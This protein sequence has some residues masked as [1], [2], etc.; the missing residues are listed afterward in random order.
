MKI[1]YNDQYYHYFMLIIVIGLLIWGIVTKKPFDRGFILFSWFSVLLLNL[2]RTLLCYLNNKL[3]LS[4]KYLSISPIFYSIALLY[5]LIPTQRLSQN[6]FSKLLGKQFN[7]PPDTAYFLT[8]FMALLLLL[9]GFITIGVL[10]NHKKAI[11]KIEKE[12]DE[13]RDALENI[14][15]EYWK[16][17]R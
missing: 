17:S 13:E 9:V 6:E 2:V 1:R 14:E 16:L 7:L 11:E 15:S 10:E 5:I 8:I 12:R 3:Y 4:G